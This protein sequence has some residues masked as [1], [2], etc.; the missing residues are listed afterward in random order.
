[1]AETKRIHHPGKYKIKE[2]DL[3]STLNGK[4]K[5]IINIFEEIVIYEDIFSN[6]MHGHVV[7]QEAV[8]LI[9]G[10]PIIGDEQ[11]YI[12]FTPSD[13]GD[14][15]EFSKVLEVYSV[16][17]IVAISQ[18]VRQ[19]VLHFVTP[20]FTKNKNN[21]I[22]KAYSGYTSDIV[23]KILLDT[24][25]ID[26]DFVHVEST[27]HTR[28]LVIPNWNPFKAI[29]YLAETSLSGKYSTPDMLFYEN[30][31]GFNFRSI[32]DM[33][34]QEAKEVLKIEPDNIDPTSLDGARIRALKTEK[35][36]DVQE[37]MSNGMYGSQLITHD[38]INKS[39][40][41]TNF[42]YTESF[43]DMP[44]VDG[45]SSAPL[46]DNTGVAINKVFLTGINYGG[47]EHVQ[48]F[49]QSRYSRM[50]QV[51]NYIQL[52]TVPGS[53]NRTIG[54]IVTLNVRSTLVANDGSQH[55]KYLSGNYLITNIKHVLLKDSYEQTLE[56]HKDCFKE[57]LESL[58]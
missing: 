5:D 15:V 54:D 11:L 16:T 20:E 24:M 9:E 46:N 55:D 30:C 26:P 10:F 34:S 21:R 29:K 23:R 17:D 40:A 27:K 48:E 42:E 14:F 47:S 8:G 3:T 12:K 38:I 44:H 18:D 6:T 2:L 36:Y 19:Y 35:M 25:H 4:D 31:Q 33:M 22:S 43:D 41:K 45:S 1:M 51:N 57:E 37:N 39:Y 32:A 28:Q 56:L 52:V 50:S 58:S 53:T 7:I 49:L 13:N